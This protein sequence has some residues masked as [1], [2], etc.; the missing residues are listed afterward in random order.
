MMVCA[1]GTYGIAFGACW[2]HN[3]CGSHEAGA[4]SSSPLSF[5]RGTVYRPTVPTGGREVARRGKEPAFTGRTAECG[6]LDRLLDGVRAGESGALIL[7]GDPGV[8]KSALLKY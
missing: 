4:T 1:W 2:T 6:R 7:R 3:F 8:G 5:E